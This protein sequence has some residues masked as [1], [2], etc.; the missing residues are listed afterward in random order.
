MVQPDGQY[1]VEV[2]ASG[3]AC[4]GV[5]YQKQD[6]FWKTIAFYSSA[7]SPAEQNYGI[8]DCK[9]LAIIKALTDWRKYLLSATQPFEIHTNHANLQFFK[10]P[11]KVNCRQARWLMILLEYHFTIHTIFL[12]HR[13]QEQMHCPEDQC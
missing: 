11:Q 9:L 10:Q 13:T 8:E 6:E 4:G 5:L 3:Y 12:D 1:K 2:D 7:M